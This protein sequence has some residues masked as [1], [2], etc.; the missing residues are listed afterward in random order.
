MVFNG[1]ATNM[2]KLDEAKKLL[3]ENLENMELSTL[4]SDI[5]TILNGLNFLYI[6]LSYKKYFFNEKLSLIANNHIDVSSNMNLKN[7]QNAHN[8][9]YKR[10]KASEFLINDFICM[11]YKLLKNTLD[12]TTNYN[13]LYNL[14]LNFNMPT[15][16][17][18]IKDTPFF[19]N[20]ITKRLKNFLINSIK[21]TTKRMLNESNLNIFITLKNDKN[22]NFL[23]NFEGLYGILNLIDDL[24]D[25]L[26]EISE[27]KDFDIYHQ[28]LFYLRLSFIR[29]SIINSKFHISRKQYGNSLKRLQNILKIN[30]LNEIA[31]EFILLSSSWKEL[32]EI[33]LKLDFKKSYECNYIYKI[34]NKLT[35]IYNF[36]Y[37]LFINLNN[38]L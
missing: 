24:Y 18:N 37:D 12:F 22:I 32:T 7:S 14:K 5:I 2:N 31:N 36:E 21:S 9:I 15:L 26:N 29:D 4:I 23:N 3:H 1:G 28:T 34:I 6:S 35:Q 27:H 8:F 10:K 30:N 20:I 25:Y 33:L 19:I 13:I 11:N 16:N 17:I 38:I